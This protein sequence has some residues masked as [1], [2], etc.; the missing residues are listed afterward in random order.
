MP[1]PASN[2][3]APAS[4]HP[5]GAAILAGTVAAL[6]LAGCQD[7]DFSPT[8][9]GDEGDDDTT[10]R[11]EDDDTTPDPGDDDGGTDEE[12]EPGLDLVEPP[13]DIEGPGDDPPD[14]EDPPDLPP[15]DE[16][17]EAA[18]PWWGSQPFSTQA[19]PVDG[20]GRPFYALDYDMVGF[21]TVSMPDAGHTPAGTDKV[22]RATFHL[23]WVP[24]KLFLSMQSDDGMWF[25]ANGELLGHWGGDWQEEG[26]VNDDASCTEYV[27]VDPVDISD[28]LQVGSNVVAARVSNP[29]MN[30]FFDVYTECEE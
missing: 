18:W 20:W 12:L 25:Y 16:T 6:G 24:D 4:D 28:L 7:Y 22:Y 3:G 5:I 11:A 17:L 23:D 9:G 30:S 15:C 2:R 21:S 1:G 14:H 8:S 27:Y 19:D 13:V 26:C 10:P 29:I